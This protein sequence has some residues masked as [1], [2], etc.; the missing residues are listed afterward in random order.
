MSSD[1][2]HGGGALSSVR[3]S[4]RRARSGG[5]L[6]LSVFVL[7]AVTTAIITGTVGYSLAAATVSARQAIV[8]V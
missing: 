5:G 8:E 3:P 4:L 2:G 1:E 6:L 7:I